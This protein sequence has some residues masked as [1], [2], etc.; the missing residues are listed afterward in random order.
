MQRDSNPQSLSCEIES[1]C[2]HLSHLFVAR[3]LD[4]QITIECRF[5]LKRARD[6][7]QTNIQSI[8]MQQI[9]NKKKV[10]HFSLI[11]LETC[12]KLLQRRYFAEILNIS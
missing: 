3:L 10:K 8:K 2:T 11:G 9:R 5:A 1:R 12:K 4:I 6:M 7:I